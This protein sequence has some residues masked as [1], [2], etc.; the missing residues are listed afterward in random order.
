MIMDSRRALLML[1]VVAAVAV[2]A[3]SAASAKR[4]PQAPTVRELATFAAPGCVGGCGSGSTVGPDGAL[5]VT[6]GKAG[7]VL[8]VDRESG[9]IRTF[10]TGLPPSIEAVGIGGA[11]D[12][13]F[14]RH[15]AYVLV[16]M[17]GP[18]F[19]Q[20][21]VV[22]GI[23]RIERDG[24]ATAIADI[25]AWS[26]EHPPATAF[27]LASG[28]QYAL[29]AF[30]GGFLVTD[31][32]HNRVL[33]VTRDGDISELIAFGDDVPTG[34]AV[35]GDTV[36]VAQAGPI[37]HLPA[38]GKVVAFRPGSP[39][40]TELAS[41][42]RLAVDTEF[43]RGHRL[44]ALSQGIWDLPVIPA[45]EGL[46]A[47]PNTGTLMRVKR[48]GSVSAVAGPLDRPTSLEFVGRSAYVVTLTGKV[49]KI[50]GVP[51]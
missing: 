12:V 37:P 46:P 27:D 22:D 43:G 3:P 51:H 50:D 15:T 19:G 35:R 32:H 4:H 8:R 6:D 10:A 13:A 14:I 11:M 2:V 30:R 20:P 16:T 21:D 47:S 45:N 48:D 31:G 18:L 41:G 44:Y 25:G 40:A 36:Y 33:R 26:I 23:Y 49:M 24:S 28:V 1:A 39:T 38:T 29:Q 9:A 5:Y 7:R 17:V 34:L 42:I